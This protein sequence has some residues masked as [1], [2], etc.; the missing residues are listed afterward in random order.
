ME[1]SPTWLVINKNLQLLYN[2]THI[3]VILLQEFR[4]EVLVVTCL[5][6]ECVLSQK[7]LYYYEVLA[8]DLMCKSNFGFIAKEKFSLHKNYKIR[9]SFVRLSK[10]MLNSFNNEIMD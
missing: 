5:M 4:D 3:N 6:M 8:V 7:E 2:H 9:K 1:N 10:I